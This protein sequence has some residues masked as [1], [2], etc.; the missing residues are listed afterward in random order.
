ME[1]HIVKTE[2]TVFGGN[3][4]AKINGKAVF[5]P[6]SM[7]EETL[8]IR[9]TQQKNDYDIAEIV[10]IITPSPNRIKPSCQYFG[11]CGGCNLMHINPNYQRELKVQMIKDIFAQN[12]IQFEKDFQINTIFGP[13]FNYRARFQF[14]DGG[15]SEKSGHK[16]IQISEC[17]CAE[18]P[19]N[20]YLQNTKPENR[21]QGRVHYFGSQ[22][23]QGENQIFIAESTKKVQNNI[24]IKKNSKKELK[25]KKNNYFSGTILS[26][27]NTASVKIKDKILKFDV[28]GFFQSNLFVFEKVIDLICTDLSG[29]NVLDM[30][31]G[32]GSISAFLADNFEHVTLVEHNRDALVFAEQ[33]MAN[34]NHTSYGLS[35]A[36]WV[37]TCAQFCGTF[38]AIVIDPPRSGMENEV[39]DYLCKSKTPVIKSLSCDIA[40]HIRDLKKLIKAGYSI[41]SFYL[42][43]FYPNTSHIESLAVLK[44]N[45]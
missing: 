42:L 15:L 2:K 41:E 4:I 18:S 36:N 6:Y 21:P 24:H 43:D 10:N 26:E 14:T 8:E 5:I 12:Q 34:T 1:T 37:K 7:P 9:I 40:T 29:K 17:K 28:R 22:K 23:V 27:E 39:C 3:T 16:I 31:S 35:G 44:Y 20:E 19:I 25:I 33:N 30:Y 32:C 38:D 45:K 11:L 13:D